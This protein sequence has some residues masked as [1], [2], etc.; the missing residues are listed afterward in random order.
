MKFYEGMNNTRIRFLEKQLCAILPR[1]VVSIICDYDAIHR[2]YFYRKIVASLN[3]RANDF[4]EKTINNYMRGRACYNDPY[5]REKIQNYY[6]I[7]WNVIPIHI[8]YGTGSENDAQCNCG[9]W[10]CGGAA[11][12]L[13]ILD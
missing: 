13:M 3:A 8:S 7:L 4:W 6:E 12:G 10:V 9:S 5:Y 11:T 1:E 2:D